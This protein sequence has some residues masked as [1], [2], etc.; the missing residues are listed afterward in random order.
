LKITVT[1]YGEPG[2]DGSSKKG[3]YGD[4]ARAARLKIFKWY[5]L[6]LIFAISPFGSLFFKLTWPLRRGSYETIKS[7]ILF[8]KPNQ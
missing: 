4:P 3:S 1:K 6:T 8:L 5:L 2:Q 7:N